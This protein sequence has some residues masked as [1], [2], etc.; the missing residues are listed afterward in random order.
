LYVPF[1]LWRWHYFGQLLPNTYHAKVEPSSALFVSGARH[2]SAFLI[3]SGFLLA[4]VSL[5]VLLVWQK[6]GF[7]WVMVAAVL[8]AAFANVF[9]VGSDSFAYYRMFLPAIPCGVVAVV[10]LCQ[11]LWARLSRATA[12]LVAAGLAAWL[13]FTFTSQFLPAYPLFGR[14][15]TPNWKRVASVASIN[16]SYFAVGDWLNGHVAPQSLM[17]TNAAGIVPYVSRLPTLDMLGLNDVHIAHRHMTLGHGAAGH[18]KHDTTYVLSRQPDLIFLGLP[19]LAPRHLRPQDVE[20]WVA[21]WFPFLPGDRELFFSAQFRQEYLP[22]VIDIGQQSLLLFA[23]KQ[24]MQ[25]VFF[26]GG[27]S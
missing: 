27:P 20:P 11:A 23:R 25:H 18:E 17:A 13:V 2:A 26:P 19:M 10:G 12:G 4:L 21:R 1:F 22:V 3:S 24:S 14:S 5:L 15:E 6:A 9:F 16:D 7:R 8:G